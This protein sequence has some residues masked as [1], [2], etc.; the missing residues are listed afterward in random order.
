VDIGG[1]GVG[2]QL[3]WQGYG[4][5]GCQFTQRIYSE[6]GYRYLYVDYQHDGFVYDTATRGAQITVGVVF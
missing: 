5:L 1:F 2:S 6:V 4:A 3:T